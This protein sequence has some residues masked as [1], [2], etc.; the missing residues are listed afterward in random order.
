MDD[1]TD[2]GIDNNDNKFCNNGYTL[3]NV[4]ESIAMCLFSFQF[5]YNCNF[6]KF[7]FCLLRN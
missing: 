5:I 3:K 6:I 4:R 1:D 2:D 7:Q